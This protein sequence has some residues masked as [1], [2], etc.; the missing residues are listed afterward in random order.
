MN[1][2]ASR[3][4]EYHALA[5]EHAPVVLV[6]TYEFAHGRPLAGARV[7]EFQVECNRVRNGS[8]DPSLKLTFFDLTTDAEGRIRLDDWEMRD[9]VQTEVD[10]RWR[11][12]ASDN[13]EQLS[14]L[15]GYRHDFLQL[16]GFEVP[17]VDYGVD[18]DPV[19]PLMPG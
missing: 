16:F 1:G 15:A 11:E 17:G 14:D 10:R 7:P 5:L 13:V 3:G 9:D 18:V 12:V 4:R 19:V 2:D 8:L 6:Q